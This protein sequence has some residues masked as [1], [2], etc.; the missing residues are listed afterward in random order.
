MF[1]NRI[2]RVQCVDDTDEEAFNALQAGSSFS[3]DGDDIRSGAW[4]S[5]GPVLVP[6]G[7]KILNTPHRCSP[8]PAESSMAVMWFGRCMILLCSMVSVSE[9]HQRCFLAA[10]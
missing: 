6:K 1:D 9:F 2:R 4:Q 8:V 7:D 3:W 10:Y 5:V